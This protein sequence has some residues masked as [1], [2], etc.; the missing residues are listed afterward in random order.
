MN[1]SVRFSVLLSIKVRAKRD[2]IIEP[3]RPVNITFTADSIGVAAELAI[4]TVFFPNHGR[5]FHHGSTVQ[6]A[7]S[8]S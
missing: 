3:A 8:S 5:A 6:A 7:S 1:R 2:F 4:Q